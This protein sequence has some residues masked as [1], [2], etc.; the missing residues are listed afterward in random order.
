MSIYHSQNRKGCDTAPLFHIK[1][2]FLHCVFLYNHLMHF[3]KYPRKKTVK[4][5]LN[6]S[7]LRKL[8][9]LAAKMAAILNFYNKKICTNFFI[10][11]NY[12]ETIFTDLY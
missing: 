12:H 7:K 11:F 4:I 1:L 6:A 5:A 3:Y 2:F 9:F 10:Y 8:I